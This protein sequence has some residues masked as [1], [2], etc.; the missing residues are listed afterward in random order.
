MLDSLRSVL[1]FRKLEFDPA[2]RRL[3]A[4]ANVADLRR[5]AKKRL[6]AGVFDYI[7][8]GAEDEVALAANTGA[9]QA[10]GFCPRV[11]RD[12]S[13]VDPSAMLL[14]RCDT[15]SRCCSNSTALRRC[16]GLTILIG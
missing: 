1:R 3:N 10:F 9:Y 15:P 11:L 13:A 16:D 14:G 8:G 12:V 5:F 4:C 2:Q 6:P 7:D